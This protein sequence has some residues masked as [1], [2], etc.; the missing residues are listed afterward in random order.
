MNTLT[1]D[2]GRGLEQ[3]LFDVAEV[4]RALRIGVSTVRSLV[5][6]GKLK[7]IRVGDRVL[8]SRRALD[9]FIAASE[10]A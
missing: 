3:M 5:A 4:A 8:V 2:Q 10:A 9:E 6:S 7:G 1:Q